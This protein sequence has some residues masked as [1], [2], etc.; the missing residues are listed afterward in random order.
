MSS[1]FVAVDPRPD[2]GC[3]ALAARYVPLPDL[4][5]GLDIVTLHRPLTPAPH[6]TDDQEVTLPV[7]GNLASVD[8][9]GSV[10]DPTLAQDRAGAGLAT[11]AVSA[12]SARLD[13]RR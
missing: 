12:S 10:P 11:E 7:A 1:T 2:P 8:L 4:L 6:H 3:E 13:R 9:G 5:A